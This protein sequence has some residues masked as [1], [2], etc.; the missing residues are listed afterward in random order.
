MRISYSIFVLLLW[1]ATC[2]VVFMGVDAVATRPVEVHLEAYR[3]AGSSDDAA[4]L[5]ALQDARTLGENWW[6]IRD[7]QPVILLDPARNYQL[8]PYL[9]QHIEVPIAQAREA[10][11]MHLIHSI[12]AIKLP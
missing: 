8:D 6:W 1:V 12:P 10:G 7:S 11:V 9:L 5:A 4:L 2:G 3:H